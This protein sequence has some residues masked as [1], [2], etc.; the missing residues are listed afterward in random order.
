M[1][2]PLWKILWQFLKYL[3]IH[4]SYHPAILLIGSMYP[5]EIEAYSH[6]KTCT[7]IF[8]PAFLVKDNNWKQSKCLLIRQIDRQIVVYPYKETFYYSAMKKIEHC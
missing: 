6:A 8:M 1:S 2:K 7:Q 5:R 4:L 3:N